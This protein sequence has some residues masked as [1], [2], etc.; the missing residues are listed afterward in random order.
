MDS[1]TIRAVLEESDGIKGHGTF[2][3]GALQFQIWSRC[4]KNKKGRL[5]FYLMPFLQAG[6]PKHA[7]VK[8][9]TLAP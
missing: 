2:S 7:K 1:P 3:I 8:V 9:M 6:G 5:S 4:V